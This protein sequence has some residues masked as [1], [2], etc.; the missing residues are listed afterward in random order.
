MLDAL[1]VVGGHVTC[2]CANDVLPE[3]PQLVLGPD[4]RY[5]EQPVEFDWASFVALVDY[6]MRLIVPI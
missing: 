2:S 4:I 1:L 3:N 5:S 6:L